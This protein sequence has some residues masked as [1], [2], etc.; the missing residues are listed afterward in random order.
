[1]SKDGQ[2]KCPDCET[3]LGSLFGEKGN[4]KCYHC[5][6]EGK[7][8]GVGDVIPGMVGLDNYHDCEECNATGQCQTCGGTGYE[9]Y[10][11]EYNNDSVL[12]VDNSSS[13][14]ESHTASSRDSYSTYDSPTSYQYSAPVKSAKDE[15]AT[16]GIRK[17]IRII[18]IIFFVGWASYQI[19]IISADFSNSNWD[20]SFWGW[21]G[22]VIAPITVIIL[23]IPAYIYYYLQLPTSYIFA[24]IITLVFF[25]LN[26]LLR[27]AK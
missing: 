27:Q 1:M 7:R 21:V 5:Q 14:H 20:G 11:E 25:V 16:F 12:E 3:D 8:Y 13:F 2:R 24:G 18:W 6:G 9:Y 15:D 10:Y 22:H 19:A 4:G 17:L 23:G 26:Y